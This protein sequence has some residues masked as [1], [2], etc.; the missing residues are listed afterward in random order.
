MGRLIDWWKKLAGTSPRP[1]AFQPPPEAR[2]S[3]IGTS[4]KAVEST[5]GP[6]WSAPNP[7]AGF[8]PRAPRA[9]RFDPA[10]T[11]T[12]PWGTPSRKNTKKKASSTGTSTTAPVA[13]APAPPFPAASPPGAT[14][15]RAP[16]KA[17]ILFLVGAAVGVLVVV[18]G[19]GYSAL[20]GSGG[21]GGGGLGAAPVLEEAWAVSSYDH[22]DY[23]TYDSADG[24]LPGSILTTSAGLVA[25]IEPS[26][27]D[28]SLLSIDPGSGSVR[29]SVP[30]PEARCAAPDPDTLLCLTRQG[31]STFDLVT[32]DVGTGDLVGEP[33][34]TEISHV[35]VLLLPLGPDGLVTLS[36][37]K[38][39]TALDLAGS[40][41][42]EE[43]LDSPDLDTSY[44]QADV[45]RY[46]SS[47]ILSF[48]WLR[49][50]FFVTPEGSTKHDCDSV[51]ATPAAWMCR[52]EDEAIGFAPDGAEL[53]RADWHDYYLID[54]Y[55]Y[56]APVMLV[57]NWD[58]TVSSVDPLTGDHGPAV[59]LGEDSSFNFLGDPEHPFVL[60]EE[61]VSLLSS[62]LTS[63]VWTA[64]VVD[65][66]LNIA[67][68]GVVEDTLVVDG[69]HSWG[70]D[71]ADGSRSWERDF[72]TSDVQV[73]DDALYGLGINEL[74]RYELP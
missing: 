11:E 4:Y 39:L 43:P 48:G 72:L 69:E 25:M 22:S 21:G 50:T 54:R 16:R 73:I 61:S 29:W 34:P 18:V 60:A 58:G 38:E 2:F 42:W 7:Y 41:R 67:G 64:P 13:T 6:T 63:V 30:M 20:T 57:D 37:D 56:I 71:I 45:A 36:V 40:T 66:Y 8:D 74:V 27:L 59:D 12:P 55:Q 10:S 62:D 1:A 9:T 49:G 14:P 24:T 26:T 5:T 51:A 15:G 23:G 68:G 28:A 19:V 3:Q 47:L 17:G 33:V 46:E 32:V 35:P 31:G 65:G 70:F 53:W 52:G 44:I